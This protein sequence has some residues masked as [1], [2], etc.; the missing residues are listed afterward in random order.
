MH[1][2]LYQ[3][4]LNDSINRLFIPRIKRTIRR[5]LISRAE[6]AAISCFAHNLRHLFWREG[7]NSAFVI[8][9]DPGF[10]AC[11]AALLTPTGSVI[12]SSEFSFNVGSFDKRTEGILRKWQSKLVTA[13]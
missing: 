6:E 9:L 3:I 5:H 1:Q 7:V 4:A 13:A 2:T 8:A 11:K 12:E 10:S